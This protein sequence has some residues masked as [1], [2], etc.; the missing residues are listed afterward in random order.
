MDPKLKVLTQLT[1][2]CNDVTLETLGVE[3]ADPS[4]TAGGEV[5]EMIGAVEMMLK[6]H[7]LI[8]QTQPM[9]GPHEDGSALLQSR[10]EIPRSK[11]SMQ[12]R[13]G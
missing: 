2:R 8:S 10:C 9:G 11:S 3:D 6:G 1:E 4:V 5:M 12:R 13:E 7:G